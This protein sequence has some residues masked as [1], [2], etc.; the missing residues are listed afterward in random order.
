MTWEESKMEKR[1]WRIRG[2]KRFETIVD[3]TVP[4]GKLS[5]NQVIALLKCLAAKEGLSYE[6]IVGAYLKRGTK[7]AN[8]LLDVHKNG[9][10][11]EYSCGGDPC[12]AAIVVDDN[13]ER[14]K[15]P[16]V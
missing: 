5:Q 6:E 16:P 4:V 11:P 7:G 10:Y 13:R 12:F 2:H 1:Y 3:L 8:G 15:Y 9:P 14:V